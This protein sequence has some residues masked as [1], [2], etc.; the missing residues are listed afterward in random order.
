MSRLFVLIP[1]VLTAC[2][3]DVGDPNYPERPIFVDPDDDF[4][5][6]ATPWTG[7]P[8]LSIGAYYEGGA[9][10][11]VL[12]DNATTHLYVYD[13][14]FDSEPTDERVEGTVADKLVASGVGWI[15]GGVHWDV[16]RDL[17]EW[18][19]LNLS[20]F[21]EDAGLGN[22]TIGMNGG[23]VE[24]SVSVSDYGFATDGEWHSLSIPLEDIGVDLS[25][26]SVA[27]IMLAD[28]VEDG[29][30]LIIDDVYFSQEDE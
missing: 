29:E 27:L 13:S 28:L 1:L 26:V 15:G 14:T 12:V 9:T 4:L 25:S 5:D 30:E 8:R 6:G 2:L 24:N 22:F 17:T 10:E 11:T 23:G 3:P 19:H 18:T 16:P 7:Q 20:L 21:S